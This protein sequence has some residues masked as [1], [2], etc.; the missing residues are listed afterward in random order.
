M[1]KNRSGI[2]IG[3]TLGM[4]NLVYCM[5]LRTIVFSGNFFTTR[6][7]ISR[8]RKV[9]SQHEAGRNVHQALR[10]GANSARHR[11][12]RLRL[13][14]T[15]RKKAFTLPSYFSIPSGVFPLRFCHLGNR[16]LDCWTLNIWALDRSC[17]HYLLLGRLK[18]RLPILCDASIDLV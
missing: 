6:V 13:C 11:P 14:N 4:T 18:V 2:L 3:N 16:W 9:P 17:T 15:Y 8:L 10:L 1:T 12:D 5:I 7:W